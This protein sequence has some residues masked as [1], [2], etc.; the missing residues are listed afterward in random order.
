LSRIRSI[1]PDWLEDDRMALA[2]DA[3]RV[4]SIALIC[5]ADDYGNGRSGDVTLAG[6][7]FPG[8]PIQALT[9]ALRELV[10]MRYVRLY[11]VD[12]QRYFNIRTWDRHQRVDKP[13]LPKVPGPPPDSRA[14][15]QE[16][17]DGE[18]EA[19]VIP[20]SSRPSSPHSESGISDLFPALPDQPANSGS[21]RARGKR[22]AKS[23]HVP[24]PMHDAWEAPSELHAALAEQ[25]TVTPERVSATTREFRHF[26]KGRGDRKKQSGWERAFS[27]NV[28]R[29][30]KYGTLYVVAAPP[31]RG[32][33]GTIPQPSH[34][35]TGFEDT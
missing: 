6:K 14:E 23:E 13:G 12:G 9:E 16:L 24:F 33:R 35:R 28:E 8:R 18:S 3:A 5:L 4:L 1:K 20:E 15:S 34:G 22:R 21:A 7:V 32:N 2:S 26:W 19:P 30:A 17:P 29:L 31:A 25:Y 11:E 27:A 10:S